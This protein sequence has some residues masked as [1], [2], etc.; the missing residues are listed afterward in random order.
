MAAKIPLNKFKRVTQTLLS[1]TREIYET[2]I[3]R[4]SVIVNALVS[5]IS[6]KTN[7]LTLSIST[8]DPSTSFT[9][10]NAYPVKEL[11]V[12]NLAF[13]KFVI[14]QGDYLIGSSDSYSDISTLATN[15]S[16][17]WEIEEPTSDVTLQNILFRATS[18]T[19]ITLLYNLNP[20]ERVEVEYPVFVIQGVTDRV[21]L[22]LSVL[23]ILNS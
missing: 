4:A 11:E 22:T 2:P 3:D 6:N 13:E 12:L 19:L 15:P 17:F 10:L 16:A 18:P 1:A 23:E 5:N 9:I 21:N 20:Q 14:T 7:T 8:H